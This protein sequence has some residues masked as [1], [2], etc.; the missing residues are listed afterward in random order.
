MSSITIVSIRLLSRTPPRQQI[1]SFAPKVPRVSPIIT[2]LRSCENLTSENDLTLINSHLG[3]IDT[4]GFSLT[5]TTFESPKIEEISGI[6][7]NESPNKIIAEHFAALE[8]LNAER[9]IISFR[10]S[11]LRIGL[12]LV[13]DFAVDFDF[14]PLN[15][16]ITASL[17]SGKSAANFIFAQTSAENILARFESTLR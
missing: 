8:I 13:S 16:P 3:G 11:S 7:V 10:R 17:N 15:A 2:A 1:F 6:S 12:R 5:I 4:G 9:I 14:P